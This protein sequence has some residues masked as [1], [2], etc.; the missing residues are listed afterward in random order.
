[1]AEKRLYRRPAGAAVIAGGIMLLFGWSYRTLAI[2]LG[3]RPNTIQIAPDA[4]QG[5]PMRIG[6]W[7][8]EDV[9]I[10]EVVARRTSTDARI[11]R[12]Y[13]CGFQSVSLYIGCG[14]RIRDMMPHRPEGC[15]IGAGW[16]RTG[17]SFRELPLGVG[18]VLPCAVVEFSRGGL[19]ATRIVVVH[20][21]VVD[22]SYCQTDSEWRY[23]Y[24]RVGYVAQVEIV[25]PVTGA[26]S[27]DETVRIACDF[28]VDS[29][30]LIARQCERIGT[31]MDAKSSLPT[32]EPRDH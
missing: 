18:A 24:W 14:T 4:L 20:Y 12:R 5:I 9:P 31:C 29:A 13:S 25:A 8:G 17:R 26:L 3:A 15:Y 10:D 32:C 11:N 28:A 1:M 7:V 6:G 30:P 21:Y 16:T 27:V 2:Q 23:R 19:N 22:G